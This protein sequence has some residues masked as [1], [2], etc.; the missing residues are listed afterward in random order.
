M[1]PTVSSGS[2][3]ALKGVQNH[4]LSQQ[5]KEAIAKEQQLHKRWKLNYARHMLEEENELLESHV[6]RDKEEALRRTKPNSTERGTL[7][8]DGL[9]RLPYLKLR[10][11]KKP[12]DKSDR[13]LTT[14]QEVG[15]HAGKASK[16]KEPL[17]FKAE[18]G[19][20]PIVHS[21]FFRQRGIF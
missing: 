16:L 6:R 15:W 7:Y 21:S 11:G 2:V 20:K 14:S 12:H 3:F 1:D 8:E 13:P 4:I 18:W 19:H 5:W 9:G 17:D 10:R